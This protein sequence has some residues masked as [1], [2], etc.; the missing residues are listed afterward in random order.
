MSA[1]N[2]FTIRVYGL[3]LNEKEEVLLVH[4][5]MP[6]LHFTKFPGGGMEFEE[7]TIDCLVREFK[8]E[9]GIDICVGEHLYTT[10]IY[11]P[12]A[13]KKG[14]QL[15]AIY[16]RVFQLDPTQQISLEEQEITAGGKIETLRFFWKSL[17][18]LQPETDLTFPIDR[19]MARKFLT[20]K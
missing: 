16:Y 19:I 14:D 13:F 8:E 18:T 4:E 2:R 15:V 6:H 11:Q 10:D 12:S 20:K 7:G 3:L 5:K 1:I 9:T 17:H